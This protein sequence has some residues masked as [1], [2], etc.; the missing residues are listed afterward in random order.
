MCLGVT[1][2]SDGAAE[3]GS[4]GS[5]TS[6]G[7]YG[8][9]LKRVLSESRK[10][11]RVGILVEH[12]RWLV[13]EEGF[14]WINELVRVGKSEQ[15]TVAEIRDVTSEI[16]WISREAGER[17]PEKDMRPDGDIDK[18]LFGL[19][20]AYSRGQRLRFDFRFRELFHC[21]E[22]WRRDYDDAL[23]CAFA[24]F[25]SCGLRLPDGLTLYRRSVDMADADKVSRHVSLT[26]IWMAQHVPNQAELL[27]ELAD[28]MITF[29]EGDAVLYFR[30]SRGYRR[31]GEYERALDNIYQAMDL[32]GPDQNLV[33]ADYVREWQ[34]IIATM[35]LEESAKRLSAGVIEE[36]QKEAIEQIKEAERSLSEGQLRMVE[37]LGLFMAL[38]GFLVAG[39]S[40]FL[41]TASWQQ[42]ITNVILIGIGSISFFVA[43]RWIIHFR[44][45][46][47]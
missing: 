25:A 24:A 5:E 31:L 18:E 8:Q 27:L 15:L 6:K 43:L 26:A 29:G 21:T 41:Q 30:R 13:G 17:I 3:T 35:D 37:I 34:I 32:V 1:T 10:S 7:R 28:T 4:T 44:K 33:H 39:G 11:E 14:P 38:V 40:T 46:G 2:V 12:I 47:K 9:D 45:S 22:E 19:V 20:L 23:I 42:A 36:T 16:A